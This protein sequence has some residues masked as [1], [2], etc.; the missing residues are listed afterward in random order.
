MPRVTVVVPTYKRPTMLDETL[1]SIRA[2]TYSDFE[3]II[4]DDISDPLTGEVIRCHVNA[5]SRVIHRR[6][7]RPLPHQW[8]TIMRGID[9]ASGEFIAIL[10]D[11]NTWEPLFLERMVAVLAERPEVDLVF[12]DHWVTD[13]QGRINAVTTDEVTKRWKRDQLT[14][15]LHQPFTRVALIDRSVAMTSATV[16]RRSALDVTDVPEEVG[17]SV[18]LWLLYLVAR[19][20]R[21][22]WYI[23]ERLSRYR[24][25]DESI[26]SN[27]G[28]SWAESS[29]YTWQRILNDDGLGELRPELEHKSAMALS[30]LGITL[31]KEGRGREA[32]PFL[33]SAIS[34]NF[35]WRPCAA[36][37]LTFMPFAISSKIAN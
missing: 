16:L 5:D 12:C 18:D 4:C 15:G 19:R 7:D 32:R 6:T 22:A 25:H 11:D 36:L 24:V 2:Q 31:L 9:E 26:T 34:H 30:C 8:G 21:G 1:I 28:S 23:A 14:P 29:V 35:A 20:K 3:I 10:E 37:A 33:R 13:H 17:A 27:G